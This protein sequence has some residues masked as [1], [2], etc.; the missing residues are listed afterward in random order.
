MV[1]SSLTGG[2]SDSTLVETIDI[3]GPFGS[4]SVSNAELEGC[5][6]YEAQIDVTTSD[7]EDATLLFGDG[8][9]Q[10]LT[11]NTTE[12]ITHQYCNSGTTSQNLTPI[13]FISSGT[14][15]GNIPAAQTITIHPIPDLSL[16]HI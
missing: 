14:C 15:N 6:C 5:S 13:L 10:S 9:F 2:C 7:V 8:S 4:I 16:I 3:G 1:V 12:T 11:I